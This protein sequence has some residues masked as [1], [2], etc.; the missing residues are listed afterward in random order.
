M[1]A[2]RSRPTKSKKNQSPTEQSS[3]EGSTPVSLRRTLL[4]ATWLAGTLLATVIVYEAVNAVAG[5]VTEPLSPPISQAGV[6]Q[7]LKHQGQATPSPSPSQSASS[8]TPTATPRPPT[9]A[10]PPG[11][12][13]APSPPPVS[14]TTNTQTFSLIGGTA[15]VSCTGGQITLNWA[16]P[17][18]GFQVETGTS[19]GGTQVEVRFR[20]DT[21]ESRL[22]AWCAGGLVQSSVREE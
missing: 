13:P 15:S 11:G 8:P 2:A 18:S 7:A 20:S 16:T 22:E 4:A 14:A 9:P 10:P 12:T 6:D 1:L 17:K 3:I 5:Q 19:N 21:H